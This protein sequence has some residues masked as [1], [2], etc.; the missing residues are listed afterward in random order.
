MPDGEG[1]YWL[2]ARTTG[3]PGRPVLSQRSVRSIKPPEV[4]QA[5]KD[6]TFIILGSG[7][8]AEKYFESRGLE[9]GNDI[10]NLNPDNNVVIIWNINKLS[11][12]EKRYSQ[13]LC[14]F[15]HNGGVIIVL[16]AKSWNW[17]ELCEVKIE[18]PR[19]FSR[20]F[21]Y[22][23]VT[24]SMLEGIHQE[25]LMRWNGLPGMVAV[26]AIEGKAM[27]DVQKILWAREPSSTVVAEVPAA[28]GKGKILFSQLDIRNHIDISRGNY[29][30][31]ADRI[32]LNMLGG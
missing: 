24:H 13:K 3:I 12:K 32:L 14:D 9:T 25:W 30:P 10:D 4:L 8:S 18:K 1:N 19:A 28:Y 16:S 27:E 31:V 6:R 23:G 29:D 11:S 22:E 20:V 21:G 15:A 17:Q 5:A 2:T 26:A 7:S